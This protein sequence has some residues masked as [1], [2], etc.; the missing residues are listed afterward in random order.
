MSWTKN[1]KLSFPLKSQHSSTYLGSILL[2]EQL[3]LLFIFQS[4]IDVAMLIIVFIQIVTDVRHRKSRGVCCDINWNVVLIYRPS[5]YVNLSYDYISKI[6]YWSSNTT[7]GCF[8]LIVILS[9]IISDAVT[10][11]IFIFATYI[12]CYLS[13]NCACNHSDNNI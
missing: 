2:H 4:E 8:V 5:T 11:M 3:F 1:I 6:V 10:L 7:S 9:I 13:P 12:F